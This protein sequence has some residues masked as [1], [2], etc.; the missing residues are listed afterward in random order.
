MFNH[1]PANYVCPF[2]LVINGVE[3]ERVQTK[4]ADIVYRDD[5]I[6]AF[7]ASCW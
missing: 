7:I 1:E 5:L 4:Q 6:T 3:N 2:C